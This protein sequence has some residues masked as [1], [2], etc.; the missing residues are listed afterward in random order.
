MYRQ[1]YQIDIQGDK[2]F[3]IHRDRRTFNYNAVNALNLLPEHLERG[4]FEK[5][6]R[7][8]KNRTQNYS[9]ISVP[10]L[11]TL[12]ERVEAEL[13]PARRQLHWE[14]I[15]Q[16]YATEL[17]VLPLFFQ[18]NIYVLPKW[19]E[20]LVPTGHLNGSTLWAEYWTRPE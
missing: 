1:I 3:T 5:E 13:D 16:I 7:E 15:Q 12:I 10:E 9:T 17:A 19:L 8:Y 6:H 20:G 14:R 18:S 11:D 4:V 2:R